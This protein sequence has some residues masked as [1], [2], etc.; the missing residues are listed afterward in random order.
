MLLTGTPPFDISESMKGWWVRSRIGV[1]LPE[2]GIRIGIH[3]TIPCWHVNKL[4][5]E[6]NILRTHSKIK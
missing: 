3:W 4:A 5:C 1:G 6:C 2:D